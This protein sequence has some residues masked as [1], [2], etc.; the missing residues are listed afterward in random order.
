[1]LDECRCYQSS[2]VTF[3]HTQHKLL[4]TARS[5]LHKCALNQNSCNTISKDSVCI[6]TVSCVYCNIV[7]VHDVL[8]KYN[9]IISTLQCLRFHFYSSTTYWQL[10]CVWFMNGTTDMD[11][12]HSRVDKQRNEP[13]RWKHRPWWKSRIVAIFLLFLT[14][15]HVLT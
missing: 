4:L 15:L 1:M 2:A 6:S 12:Y 11:G 13:G 8:L 3:I 14:L 10:P 9:A 5:M 7:G